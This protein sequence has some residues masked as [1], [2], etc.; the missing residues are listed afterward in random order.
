MDLTDRQRDALTEI[1]NIAIGRAAHSLNQLV[2]E[3]INLTIPEIK[4]LSQDKALT[5]YND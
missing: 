3:E 4:F 1:M 5:I 2:K